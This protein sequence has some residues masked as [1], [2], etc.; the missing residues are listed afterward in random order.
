MSGG[1]GC[2]LSLT[3]A[4]IWPCNLA[5]AHCRRPAMLL[6]PLWRLMIGNLLNFLSLSVRVVWLYKVVFGKVSGGRRSFY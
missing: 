2:F 3:G 6:L 5:P 1:A 4:M